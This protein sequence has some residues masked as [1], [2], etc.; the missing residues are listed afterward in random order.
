MVLCDIFSED[1]KNVRIILQIGLDEKN[2]SGMLNLAGIIVHRNTNRKGQ[3]KRYSKLAT[4]TKAK[5]RI[6]RG[7]LSAYMILGPSK[8]LNCRK[9]LWIILFQVDF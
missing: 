1:T 8:A 7:V 2:W 5:E 9:T 4:N 6:T 3:K